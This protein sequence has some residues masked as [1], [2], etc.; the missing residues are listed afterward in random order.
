MTTHDT[1]PIEG[2]KFG[3]EHE[4]AVA[5]DGQ[6][7]DVTNAAFSDFEHVIDELPFHAGDYPGLRVGDLGIK[8][9]R[10]YIEG[11]ERFDTCG[12]YLF[13]E[14]KGFEIRTPICAS[15]DEAV[16]TLEGDAARWQH[17]AQRHGY[18][19]LRTAIN[20]YRSAYL[21]DPPLNHWELTN[22]RSPEEQTADI[23]MVTFGPDISFS[24][25]GLTTAHTIDIG[26]KLTFASPFI[27]AFS[28][29][30]PFSEGTEWGG[31]SRR[32]HI[33]TGPRPAVLVHVGDEN[34]IIPSSPTLTDRARIPAEVG[35]IE[36]K[37]F[38]CIADFQLYRSL[39]TLL[40]GLALDSTIAGRALTPSAVLHQ[41]CARAGF[42]DVS[43]AEGAEA[44]LRAARAALP[45][46]MSADL[47]PL[48]AM[49]RDRRTPA[50]EMIRTYRTT[51]SLIAAIS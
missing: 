40:L 38:D 16:S 49:L 35:R 19:P 34:E 23:P 22:R 15:L 30:S 18:R 10:W 48:T 7:C 14:P 33:R 25:P 29:S 36:F 8:R 2:F 27:V 45:H 28:F 39:G 20:P 11:F 1:L 44:A 37:A 43:I 31:L 6:F 42:E 24:H 26:Q 21:P 41:R 13:T 50:Q 5:R 4:F 12:H 9:K 47:E 17:V 3:I 46:E 32:T 51:G